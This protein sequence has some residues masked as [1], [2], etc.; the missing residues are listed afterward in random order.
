[1]T[2]FQWNNN[3]KEKIDT[4]ANTW[5]QVNTPYVEKILKLT[6]HSI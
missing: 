6:P 3:K 2:S 4:H 1:M 5:A